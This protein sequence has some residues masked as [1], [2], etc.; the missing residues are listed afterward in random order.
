MLSDEYS[1]IIIIQSDHGS[2]ANID[3]E[4]PNDE[5]YAQL[6]GIL[7]AYHL[8]NG[9]EKQIYETIS[10][11]NSFR[12][13]FNYYFNDNYELLDDK[14]YFHITSNYKIFNDVT[15]NLQK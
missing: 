12:V 11:V 7:N 5:M 2:K 15:S 1:P 8:P 6:F 13:I 10:P 9:G 3:W 4:N 14:A